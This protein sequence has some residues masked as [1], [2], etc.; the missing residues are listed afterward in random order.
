MELFALG[1]VMPCFML[2]YEEM[3][4]NCEKSTLKVFLDGKMEYISFDSIRNASNEE[5]I[6]IIKGLYVVH[7]QQNKPEVLDS[8]QIR[9]GASTRAYDF[10]LPIQPD[11]KGEYTKF[12]NWIFTNS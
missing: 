6:K 4:K 10:N 7:F 11:E 9:I 5:K 8:V 12:C 3:V 1:K 2:R